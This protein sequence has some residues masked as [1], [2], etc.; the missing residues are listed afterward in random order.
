VRRRFERVECPGCRRTVSAYVPHMG[1]GSDVRIVPH[2]AH[3]ERGGHH[4][5]CPASDRLKR[6]YEHA[7]QLFEK[8]RANV[9]GDRP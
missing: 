3:D 6:E 5:P 7:V 4:G 1:D 8:P 2:N 9:E